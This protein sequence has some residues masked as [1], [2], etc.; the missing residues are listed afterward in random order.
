MPDQPL[1]SIVINNYN[2]ARYINVAI[3]SAL[4]QSYRPLEVVVVDDGSAD[5]SRERIASY[6]DQ[7]KAVLKENGGQTSAMNAGFEH[8]Q[9][10][11]V[12][13]LD[14]DDVLSPDV[15]GQAAAL[16][17]ADPSAVL[18]HWRMRVI[19]S[20]GK[21]MDHTMPKLS[22]DE[23]IHLRDLTLTY[24]PNSYRR[25]PTSGAA[26]RRGFLEKAA[27]FP[28][29]EKTLGLSSAAVDA[30]LSTL[31][32]LY[33]SV[34]RLSKPSGFYRVHG[35]NSY[36]TSSFDS[37]VSRLLRL[38][39]LH[40]AALQ[41]H[42]DALGLEYSKARWGS[43]SWPHQVSAALDELRGLIDLAQPFILIDE[44]QWGMDATP[45][46]KMIPFLEVDGVY[47][48]RPRNDQ[49]AIDE[50][51]RHRRQGT[52]A[53]VVAWPAYWWLDHYP[54]FAMH[55]RRSARC[56]VENDR[57]TVFDLTHSPTPG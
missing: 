55:L 35:S 45:Q 29:F 41:Q 22:P 3:D 30:Y 32:P 44:T 1:F 34:R 6:G 19:N 4:A 23:G 14:S 49:Q 11:Y 37:K 7:I 2:Y 53:V 40:S 38:Y 52:R 21:A 54:A 42:C 33:G 27:P 12:I 46:R 18:V 24:G 31:A 28:A 50:L 15:A 9:G 8:A 47:W 16:F 13:F 36:A 48:G 10:E 5:D 51:E 56:L 25:P 43:R 20:D 26:W 39:D 57:I 17:D